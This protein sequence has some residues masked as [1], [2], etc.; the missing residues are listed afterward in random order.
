MNMNMNRREPDTQRSIPFWSNNP[1][2]LFQPEYIFE[3]FP[4]DSMTY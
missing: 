2:V 1:N 3:F 4:I